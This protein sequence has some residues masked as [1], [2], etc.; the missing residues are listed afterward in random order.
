[1]VLILDHLSMR[2]ALEEAFLNDTAPYG[3]YSSP[4]FRTVVHQSLTIG[5]QREGYQEGDSIQR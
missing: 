3:P 2:K 1:M 5:Y 4:Q